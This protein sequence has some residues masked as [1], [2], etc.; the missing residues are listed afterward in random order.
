MIQIKKFLGGTLSL[1]D[2][3]TQLSEIYTMIKALN[4]LTRLGMPHTKTMV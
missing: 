1:M 2:H 3:T 4:K